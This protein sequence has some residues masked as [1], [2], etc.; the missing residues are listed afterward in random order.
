MEHFK[1]VARRIKSKLDEGNYS[2]ITIG[3]S[4]VQSMYRDVAKYDARLSK[5]VREGLQEALLDFG[6]RVFPSLEDSDEAVRF[7]RSNTI[8]WD[9][10]SNLRYP[11]STSDARLASLIKKIKEDPTIEIRIMSR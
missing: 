6:I 5:S 1:E 10:V 2:F 4:E 7:F 8:L 11:D 3:Y 9:I